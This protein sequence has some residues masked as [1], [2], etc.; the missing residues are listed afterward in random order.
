MKENAD[1][2]I[3]FKR[4]A[5]FGPAS[6]PNKRITGGG[7]RESSSVRTISPIRNRE[8]IVPSFL[9]ILKDR[10]SSGAFAPTLGEN[11]HRPPDPKGWMTK[12]RG[13]S[14]SSFL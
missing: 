10:Y 9:E 4:R 11:S 2:V 7:C 1:R 14:S 3:R 13:V 5:S 8:V 6:S 12:A